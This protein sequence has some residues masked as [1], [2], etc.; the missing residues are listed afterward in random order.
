M[1]DITK[2]QG[3]LH[4]NPAV[5]KDEV[6]WNELRE[7]I[8]INKEEKES[9]TRNT[10]YYVLLNQVTQDEL[11]YNLVGRGRWKITN[12]IANE[13][14]HTELVI[15][16]AREVEGKEGL[17]DVYFT[18]VNNEEREQEHQELLK[19]I[20][21]VVGDEAVFIYSGEDT[22][23]ATGETLSGNFFLK[24]VEKV[25]DDSSRK[26]AMEVPWYTDDK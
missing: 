9:I 22:N 19:R 17:V 10:S 23:P 3:S 13:F 2:A 24:V 18:P 15:R 7:L 8:K 5:K 11:S 6:L 12:T 4:I 1:A 16:K 14:L 25:G 21:E 26:Y 20:K